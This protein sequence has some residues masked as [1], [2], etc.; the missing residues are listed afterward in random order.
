MTIGEILTAMRHFLLLCICLGLILIVLPQS[1]IKAGLEKQYKEAYLTF[2]DG[3][4]PLYT[5]DILSILEEHDIKALF[6]VVGEEV[7]N[8]QD[9]LKAI[10]QHGHLIGNHTYSHSIIKNMTNNQLKMEIEKTD[11]LIESII[12]YEPQYFR[13]PTGAYLKKEYNLISSLGKSTLMWDFGLEKRDINEAED[14]VHYL[15]KRIERSLENEIIILLHDGDPSG[16][17]SR[18]L[19]VQA[20]PLLIRTL[21]ERGYVI[22][23]VNSPEGLEFLDIFAK[24]NPK[25]GIY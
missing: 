10:H 5:K 25:I 21:K 4:N 18:E 2:D 1:P 13:P 8:N 17:Y 3:P 11:N 23:D 12:G 16:K 20:L 15:M 9:M 7:E 22:K 14:L 24:K 6:F 19:T